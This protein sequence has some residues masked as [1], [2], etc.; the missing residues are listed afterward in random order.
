MTPA[1]I[2]SVIN[3]YII[4]N[5]TNQVTPAK[6]RFVLK[7]INNAIQQ[8]DAS[9]VFAILPLHF[10]PFT[11]Q[12]SIQQ[13]TATENGYLTFADYNEFK[14]NLLPIQADII[15]VKHK[16]WYNGIKNTGTNIELGDICQGFGA[17]PADWVDSMM[18]VSLG[19]DQDITNYELI[20]SATVPVLP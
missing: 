14:Q 10:D 16:G 11:N 19:D 13:V 5:N 18:Y 17:T 20:Y 3:A 7:T 6:M 15:E 2:E 12:F 8:S 1:E 4:D 9:A